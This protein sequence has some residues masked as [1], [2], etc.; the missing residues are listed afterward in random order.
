MSLGNSEILFLYEAKLCNPNGDPDDENRPRMDPRTRRN[1]VSDVRLKRY[2]RD[3]I[4]SRFGEKHIWV[5]KLGN[6]HVDA[7]RRLE[8]IMGIGSDELKNIAKDPEKRNNMLNKLKSKLIDLRLFGATVPVKGEEGRGGESIALTGPVQFSWGF[9][10]HPVELV[11]SAS[12]TS[13]F[14][15][16][17]ERYGTIGKDWR[18]YYSL[19]AFY[20]V[21]SGRRASETGLREN[22]IKILDDI[23][24]KAL[25]QGAT[26]RSKVGQRPLFYMRI[27]YKDNETLLGDL[28]RFIRTEYEEPIRELS[29]V[30]VD[31]SDLMN[32]LRMHHEKIEKIYVRC[33]EDF[34]VCDEVRNAFGNLV[35]NVEELN[36]R[37]E[38]LVL[39]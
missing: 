27:E 35:A 36:L 5:T 34:N 20:G 33:S 19:I 25:L 2:F 26:T 30:R 38:D 3:Y 29:N 15:G 7:T 12:I 37:P 28:R 8:A 6:E 16:R 21:I 11:D 24:W 22:D 4:I 13:M 23:L 9:S 31:L 18:L 10:L 32:Y 14:V 1:L 17:G 39:E